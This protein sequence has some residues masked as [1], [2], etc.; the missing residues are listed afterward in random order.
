MQTRAGDFVAKQCN[1]TAGPP[2]TV[3][4]SVKG[5]LEVIDGATR[6]N[7]SGKFVTEAGMVMPW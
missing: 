1:Y 7:H 5:M 4:Q 2:T 3:D 6:E